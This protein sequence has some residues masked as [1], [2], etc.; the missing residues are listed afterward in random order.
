MSDQSSVINLKRWQ[1]DQRWNEKQKRRIERFRFHLFMPWVR[2]EEWEEGLV[3]LT[4]R[5]LNGW[6]GKLACGT[7]VP[8]RIRPLA[9]TYLSLHREEIER[10]LEWMRKRAETSD[11]KSVASPMC[12]RPDA[13]QI[14]AVFA[15]FASTRRIDSS[16]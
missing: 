10:E 12:I 4:E 9:E 13:R 6:A 2:N 7:P 5:L 15:G 16:S 3:P 14:H 8:E 11:Y 1:A